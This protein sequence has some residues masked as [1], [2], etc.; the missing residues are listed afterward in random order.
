M[1][2]NRTVM[3]GKLRKMRGRVK[4]KWA[5]L[6]DDDVKVIESKLDQVAGL[7]QERYGY[8]VER[9][10]DEV[11]DYI[12]DYSKR[13]RAMVDDAIDKLPSRKR[14]RKSRNRNKIMLWVGM[15]VGF[16]LIWRQVARFITSTTPGQT[17]PADHTRPTD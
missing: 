17:R 15:I 13:T 10:W 12:S 5:R 4:E 3:N 9:S 8:T 7:L 1:A 14:K 11:T 16:I 6:T 2:F